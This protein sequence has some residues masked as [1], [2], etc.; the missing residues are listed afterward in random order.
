[1]LVASRSPLELDYSRFREMDANPKVAAVLRGIELPRAVSLL[2]DLSN[3][4]DFTQPPRS[5]PILELPP[6]GPGGWPYP[7]TRQIGFG[8]E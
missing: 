1:M 8:G 3:D 6:A 2:G 7:E 4:F 5:A